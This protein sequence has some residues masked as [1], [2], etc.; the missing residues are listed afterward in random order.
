[1]LM[2]HRTEDSNGKNVIKKSR[3]LDLQSLYDQKPKVNVDKGNALKRKRDPK[4]ESVS[5]K[6]SKKELLL[7]SL[8]SFGKKRSRK[9]ELSGGGLTCG[10]SALGKTEPPSSPKWS[11]GSVLSG[12]S[13]NLNGNSVRVPKRRRDLVRRKKT[14][15]NLLLKQEASSSSRPRVELA[16]KS[17]ETAGELV[18]PAI[19]PTEGV[20]ESL[21]PEV[22]L[23]GTKDFD[24]N[25][26]AESKS[27]GSVHSEVKERQRFDGLEENGSSGF[28]LLQHLKKKDAFLSAHNGGFPSKK[29][30]RSRKKNKGTENDVALEEIKPAL[31][32]GLRIANDLQEDDEENL[33]ANAARMLSSRFDP[34]CTGFCLS[35]KSSKPASPNGL[36]F[37]V[38]SRRD[39]ACAFSNSR[40]GSGAASGDAAD[41]VLRPRDQHSRKE[42]FRK[43]RHFYEVLFS[44]FNAYWALNQRIKV[45]WPLDQSWY[46]GHVTGYDPDKKL[47][48]VK[49][50]D[51]EEEWIDLQHE[52]FKLLLFPSE[53]PS[54][55]R[56]KSAARG[57]KDTM[58]GKCHAAE[59]T[60]GNVDTFVDSEPISSWLASSTRH[61]KSTLVGI[62]KKLKTSKHSA[63]LQPAVSDG[64]GGIRSCFSA[65]SP[66]SYWSKLACD[67]ASPDC[68]VPASTDRTS[69]VGES[70]CH[71]EK[72]SP[73]VYFRR[74]IRRREEGV[75]EASE[76]K[77]GKLLDESLDSEIVPGSIGALNILADGAQSGELNESSNGWSYH[78]G[79]SQ[80][81]NDPGLLKLV[82]SSSHMKLLVFELPF[83]PRYSF[84]MEN[85]RLFHATLLFHHGT[86]VAGWPNVHLEML[87]VDNIVGLRFVLFEG[88]LRQAVAY[89]FLILS[90]FHQYSV[91]WKHGYQQLP[92][93]SIRIKFSFTQYPGK[94]FVSEIYYFR[95]LG[96]TKWLYLESKLTSHSLLF[97]RLPLS[98]C[99][100]NNIKALESGCIQLVFSTMS[101]DTSSKKGVS[102][103]FKQRRRRVS[104]E[105]SG[106]SVHVMFSS[107]NANNDLK[108]STNYE[109]TLS[110]TPF[111]LIFN[112]APTFFLNLHLKLLMERSIPCINF[113]GQDSG[114]LTQYH[115]DSGC[116]L[117][118][119]HSKVLGNS[120]ISG[121]PG[122][123]IQ[124]FSRAS[125]GSEQGFCLSC[126]NSDLE[127]DDNSVGQDG[128]E[129]I[130]EPSVCAQ[131]EGTV[132][133]TAVKAEAQKCI[134]FQQT[135]DTIHLSLSAKGKIGFCHINGITVE[136][137]PFDPLETS[138][139]CNTPSGQH[140]SELAWDMTEGVTF[141]PDAIASTAIWHG[142]SIASSGSSLMGSV[143]NALS[144]S[145]ADFIHTGFSNG[146]KKPRTQVSYSLPSGICDF[147]PKN[148]AQCAQGFSHRRIR[149]ASE[150]RA[151]DA[152]KSC[153]R[154]VLSCDANLLVTVAD[155]GWRECGARIFL[156]LVDH[157]DWGLLV[158][159]GGAIKYSHRAHQLL[160]PGSAN[161]YTHAMMWKGGKE[162]AL[163]FPDRTQWALFKEI[164]EECYNRNMRAALVKN[165]PI[166]GV[167]LI[168]G[169]DENGAEVP[170]VR[171]ASKY[172]R[173]VET[174]VD[175]AMNLSRVLYDLD[176]EDELWISGMRSSDV[177]HSDI[178]DER[179]E[180]IMDM[181]EKVAYVKQR[182][183][184]STDE[185]EESMGGVG[186]LKMIKITYE[187]WRKKR[188]KK[189]LP[190]IRH[191]Q[192]P[193]WEKYQQE[194]KEWELARINS[195]IILSNSCHEKTNPIEKPTMF[196]FCLKPRGLEVP[197]KGTKQRS[198]KKLSVS[199]KTNYTSGDFDN[200]YSY[201]RRLSGYSFGDEKFPCA[202]HNYGSSES[203]LVLQTS[204]RMF[205]PKDAGILG[206]L[207]LNSDAS[208]WSYYPELYRN[209]SKKMGCISGTNEPQM[210]PLYSHRIMHKRNGEHGWNVNLPWWHSPMHKIEQLDD[211]D[212]DEFRLRDAASAA[213]HATNMATLKREKAQRLLYRADLAIHKAVVALMTAEAIKAASEEPIS[214]MD[215]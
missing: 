154:S 23:N 103:I 119:D 20:E 72:K 2:E 113:K 204:T 19:K 36:S 173:Q 116:L 115:K 134:S 45:F 55:A 25:Q 83:I 156:E 73:I 85:L 127:N 191:F 30:R 158:K 10:P 28:D 97:K 49:Y 102:K 106:G 15:V 56:I 180:K 133:M 192:P 88:C 186:P 91:P 182:D 110:L 92:A 60:N 48:H 213:Q 29:A 189:G 195:N 157:N 152:T 1:M 14:D 78:D 46:F 54:N 22:E 61:A 65:S 131:P 107:L 181:L 16:V 84:G 70:S 38:S 64:R 129:M 8:S 149:R 31:D 90:I 63:L 13:L 136:I 140:S 58:K 184:F 57:D 210:S 52:R 39:L 50:D 185:L 67:S 124:T 178:S 123:N 198:Q 37:S 12:I 193:L 17:L 183:L 41:R 71:V 35:G 151:L 196:A 169:G 40:S 177:I 165:I 94:E 62:A 34:S 214:D 137:P 74:R 120:S 144:D 187:H 66:S 209:K 7:S 167:H 112:A 32:D 147:S 96:N 161:R 27:N 9:G 215:E 139:G 79:F 24:G 105:R 99:T 109:K 93:T 206:H 53:V 145:K 200:L 51:R 208:E 176:S 118:V 6:K 194:L 132:E 207:P 114:L 108:A 122:S 98:E 202:S 33:E 126:S 175:M 150:K 155:R 170:F 125:S 89:V 164:H 117:E 142:D 212:I 121:S 211:S 101:L 141:S 76:G 128:A 44:D 171:P 138:A 5:K 95:E 179:F 174:D 203:S 21:E 205:S 166:P 130:G 135:S 197:N 75:V 168:E 81:A 43:R 199:V 160:Q 146:P 87:F 80:C 86:V 143:P 188:M 11:G 69:F 148:S 163:E 82:L 190:L 68:F 26:D 162:W 42:H 18:V 100:Y 159:V 59:E 172:F 104:G 3:S 201:G 47:H 4:D 153:E 111:A 77:S